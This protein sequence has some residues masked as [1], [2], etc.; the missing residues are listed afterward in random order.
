MTGPFQARRRQIIAASFLGATTPSWAA[1]EGES[2][3]LSRFVAAG[4]GNA[5]DASAALVAALR[6]ASDENRPLEIDGRF[7]IRH[8]LAVPGPVK[9]A[10]RPGQND[11]FDLIPAP[12]SVTGGIHGYLMLNRAKSIEGVRFADLTFRGGYDAQGWS[13]SKVVSVV[14]ISPHAGVVHRNIEFNRC[15]F[16]DPSGECI[17]AAPEAEGQVADL[18]V[19][20]CVADVTVPLDRTSRVANL[21]RTILGYQDWPGHKES[22]GKVAIS[23]VKVTRCKA[24]GIRTLADLKRG[25]ADFEVTECHTEDMSD[26]HHS[27]DGSFRGLFARLDGVQ[28]TPLMKAKNFIE[29]QGEDITIRDFTYQGSSSNGSIAGILITQYAFPQEGRGVEHQSKR[30]RIMNGRLSG[31]GSHAIRLLA[32]ADVEVRGIVVDDAKGSA[33]SVESPP[34]EVTPANI[35]IADV[36]P[37]GGRMQS[38]VFIAPAA[39]GV[40]V[41]GVTGF[42]QTTTGGGRPD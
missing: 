16:I 41:Q 31:I 2:L 21:V 33:V 5:S 27:A 36:K 35:T 8:D 25:T 17:F 32:P 28:R 1:G 34:G 42:A 9:V 4:G 22:Y 39:R 10:G 3:K 19:V 13:G 7:S 14:A 23:N 18:R 40:H 30:I 20:E 6:Q 12:G 11:G 24:R 38:G 15:T 26:C 37:G 29:V